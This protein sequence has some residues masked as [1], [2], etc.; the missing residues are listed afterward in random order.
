M[1]AQTNMTPINIYCARKI[2][3]A[4][5]TDGTTLYAN[6]LLAGLRNRKYLPPVVHS[7]QG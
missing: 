6:P 1:G 5:E 3:V 2:E 4:Q 7:R